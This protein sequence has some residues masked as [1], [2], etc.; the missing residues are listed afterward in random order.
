[1]KKKIFLFGYSKAN[2]GDDFFIYI[3]SK[4][5]PDL[6]F[7]IQITNEKYKK[8][9]NNLDNIHILEME[10]D[11]RLINIEEF[12]AYIYIG[13]SIFIESEY[14]KHELK[15]FTNFINKCNEKNKPFFYMTCNFGPY[16]TD[17]YLQMAKDLLKNCQNVCFRDLKSYNLFKDMKNVS[18][19][20]DVAFSYNMDAYKK[21]KKM[22]DIGI[23]VIDLSIRENLREKEL[24]YLDYMKRIVI[25]FAKRGYRVHL[26]SFCD[27]EN[28]NVAIEKIKEAVPEKYFKKL[29]VIQ[30]D[31]NIEEFLKKYS[32]M[33][34][35]VC[36]RFHAMVLSVI[37]R[38][39][40]YHLSY[41]KKSDNTIKELNIP[42]RLDNIQEIQYETTLKMN[43]FQAID[44]QTLKS[45]VDQ[46]N[47]QFEQFDQ[48]LKA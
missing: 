12:D 45:I 14:S 19:A 11:V 15:E 24:I 28:D 41:S 27:F 38:Q 20:P 48:W 10:R 9:F 17:A 22:L 13:G 3:M 26:I 47:K 29:H 1:M 30:Y 37:L 23:S 33:K 4:R 8:P 7:Y 36:T 18:Y 25:K 34:Y 42:G 46:S 32:K 44:K 5:Y 6:D 43:D 21:N 2:F 35:M 31:G 40:I 16:H 39:K